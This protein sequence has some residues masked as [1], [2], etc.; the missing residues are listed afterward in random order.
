M[1][2]DRENI[3]LGAFSKCFLKNVLG[4]CFVVGLFYFFVKSSGRTPIR[5][6]WSTTEI[7]GSSLEGSGR[8]HCSSPS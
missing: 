5:R 8:G 1:C 7:K 2:F 4:F 3:P 6:G